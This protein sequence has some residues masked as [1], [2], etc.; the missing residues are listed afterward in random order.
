MIMEQTS[1]LRFANFNDSDHSDHNDQG[2]D[3]LEVLRSRIND[4]K[5]IHNAIQKM[6]LVMSNE[7]SVGG[8][9]K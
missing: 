4:E 5:Y 8:T 2:Y 9:Q 3:R 1:N 7:L 6:A